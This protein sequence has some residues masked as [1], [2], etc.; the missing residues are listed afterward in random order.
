MRTKITH[1]SLTGNQ[2]R[3]AREASGLSRERFA[4][5]AG[6][7]SQTISDFEKYGGELVQGAIPTLRCLDAELVKLAK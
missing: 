2:L 4:V 5:A 7:S 6:L 3:A 1:P